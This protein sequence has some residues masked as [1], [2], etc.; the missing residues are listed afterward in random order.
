MQTYGREN[1]KY[2]Y[3]ADSVEYIN[4]NTI[5]NSPRT[6]KQ[7]LYNPRQNLLAVVAKQRRMLLNDGKNKNT[8]I[9]GERP[10]IPYI[11]ALS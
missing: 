2:I 11:G 6:T 7:L 1:V 10:M 4:T 9:N 8:L 3:I 5:E